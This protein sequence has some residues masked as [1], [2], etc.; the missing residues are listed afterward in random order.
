M[1]VKYVKISL[2]IVILSI[3]L[4]NLTNNTDGIT[5]GYPFKYLTIY[6]D[7]ISILEPRQ[8]ILGVMN[9]RVD[10]F[11]IDNIIIYYIIIIISKLYNLLKTKNKKV[12]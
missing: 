2:V 5:L 12:K 8:S 6:T 9:I 11:I 4:P 7:L 10:F 3:L 1:N